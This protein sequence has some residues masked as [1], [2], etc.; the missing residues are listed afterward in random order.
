MLEGDVGWFLQVPFMNLSGIRRG[1]C[2]SKSH[3][4]NGTCVTLFQD[5][6]GFVCLKELVSHKPRWCTR[7]HGQAAIQ[8]A[9]AWEEGHLAKASRLGSLFYNQQA[10]NQFPV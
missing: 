9:P 2:Y 1:N 4:G 6:Y 7:S 8:V 10:L 3:E 5:R